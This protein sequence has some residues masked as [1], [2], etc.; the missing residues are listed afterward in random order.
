LAATT[1]VEA[2]RGRE[3]VQWQVYKSPW[4]AALLGLL[5]LNILAAT[6]ARFPWRP[7]RRG[8]LLT[9][10][11]VLVLLAGAL[12][13]FWAG[14]EG[15]LILEEG[16]AADSILVPDYSRLRTAWVGQHDRPHDFFFQ[17]G[18]T[19]WPDG[20]TLKLHEQNGVRLEVLKF[21][22]HARS[23]E[24]WVADS[25]AGGLPAIL[26]ALTGANGAAVVQQW[27]AADPM[28]DEVYFGPIRV[29]FQR[30]LAASMLEDFLSPPGADKKAPD[31]ILSVHVDGRMCRIPVRENIGKK[32]S[33][34]TKGTRVEIAAYLPDARP[35]ATMHFT[36]NSQRPNNP[37]LDLKVYL[38]GKDQPVRQI[39][40]AKNPLLNLDMMH[41][42]QC[43]V[44]FWYHH[45]AAAPEAGV[46]FL[47][48]PD[49]KL[50]YRVIADGKLASRGEVKEGAPIET[51]DGA[52]LAVVKHL[53]QA[54]QKTDFL[55]V[56][57]QGD[58]AAAPES[59]VLV[60]VR[61]GGETNQVWLKRRD[62]EQ[63]SQPITTP[64][65]TL[66]VAFDCEQRPLGFSVKLVKFEHELNPGMMGDA[67][68]T[69]SVQVT[70]D[71]RSGEMQAKIAMNQ[72][73]VYGGWRFCQSG[74][75]TAGDGKQV[76]ILTAVS[77]PGD[78]LKYL[79]CTMT[80]LGMVVVYYGSAFSFLAAPWRWFRRATGKSGS[81][82]RTITAGLL[83]LLLLSGAAA[84]ALAGQPGAAAFDWHPW[85]ALPVQEGGRTKPL[86]TLAQ[87]TLR[88]L[89]NMSGLT[90][91]R[92]QLRLDPTGAFLALLFTG[93]GWEAPMAS[94][95]A[96]GATGC[97]GCPDQFP[98][99][100]PD[101][102]DREPLLLVDSA[103]LRTALGL[104]ANRTHISYLDLGRGEITDPKTGEKSLFLI[105][106]RSLPRDKAPKHG[107]LEGKATELA[108]R[109]QAFRALR[110]GELLNV[111]PI[112]G[113]KSQE[114]IS[115]ARLLQTDWDGK[116]DPTG[117][118]RRAKAELKKARAAF[119][120]GAAGDFNAASAAFLAAVREVGPQL[121]EYP[122]AGTI[123]LEVAYN[124]W[125][126]FHVA[127]ICTLLALI[128]VWLA[129]ALR[130]RPLYRAALGLYATGVL[131][132]AAG[133][134]VR[135]KLSEH[136]PVTNMY[137]SVVFVG[138]AAALFGLVAEVV[139][140]KRYALVAAAVVSTVAL[141]LADNC[142]AIL[143][144]AI[145]PLT[146]ILRSNFWLAIHVMTIM[147][148]YA[149][150][151][152]ALLIGNIT[153]GFYLKRSANQ[154]A[155]AALSKLN[156]RFLQAGV[157]LL[158]LGTFL[159]AMWGNNAWGRFWAWD[160]KETWA[161]I[162][163][164]GYLALLHARKVGW[165]RDL[166]L[167]AFSVLC[168]ALILMA[169]YGVNFVL[170]SGLHSYGSG[171]SSSHFYVLGALAIQFLY[172]G[173]ATLRAAD[174]GKQAPSLLPA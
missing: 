148:S 155:V 23:D 126:P 171:A 92:T 83:A 12:A 15:Q 114:W 141:V 110:R 78:F 39:A 164:L 60:K 123:G 84:A 117:Q 100:Q 98:A 137:E 167:A 166:G 59:A 62:P 72:P 19:D 152:M 142:P 159:G 52:R 30:V 118:I 93:Q 144:P 50:H 56:T 107:S 138:F 48:T 85:Q 38:P 160:P 131:V 54:R 115:V 120:A 88:A 80:C 77:D 45:P 29:T 82:G 134:C 14:A 27:F 153:L 147:L 150:L 75:D 156:L 34:G 143:D 89:S 76:S 26:L 146:P 6:L 161:L 95:H 162:T 55:P 124:H 35:D 31:G 53:P 94:H 168:F 2:E 63:G 169:W 28:A 173:A 136:V 113:S 20:M 163:A 74:C 8:F 133:F 103:A 11:G 130:Q 122:S 73:L 154:P 165:V 43:P 68:F 79:G 97:P 64:E 135:A 112:G 71:A 157:L 3:Y 96:T 116:T 61:A 4:F 17:P 127:W 9:H 170:S 140:R 91:P 132:M 36:T 125:V 102:W 90:D 104:S 51:I 106:I 65:G 18:P 7:G 44:Q 16:Q 158:L 10:A 70:D 25:S 32:V 86:D 22:R 66:N 67:S 109:Y 128:G 108:E 37:M 40:F 105:W 42:R 87:E 119:L 101:A 58:D 24:Q 174:R 172:V 33:A 111:L 5:A 129:W 57:V 1:I 99:H 49:E 151:A 47:Q 121:G 139:F 145:R 69:S 13:T 46:Q 81:A 149:A 41:G 21:Y